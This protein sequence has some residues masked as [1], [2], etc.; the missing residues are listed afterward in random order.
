MEQYEKLDQLAGALSRGRHARDGIDRA[1]PWPWSMLRRA[2]LMPFDVVPERA[3]TRH[4]A[5]P[6]C[7]AMTK[8]IPARAR[9]AMNSRLH[10]TS[11]AR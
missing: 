5:S 9:A 2:G 7:P 11:T 3:A 4:Y 1:R 8:R 6:R 10:F